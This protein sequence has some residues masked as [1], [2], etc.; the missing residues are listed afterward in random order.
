MESHKRILGIIFIVWGIL[1]IFG[2]IFLIGFFSV[3][4]PFLLQEVSPED[5]WAIEWLAPFFQT[6]GLAI[7]FV[8]A[9]PAIIAGIGLLNKKTWAPTMA[10]IFGCLGVFNF[11]VG[12]AICGYSIWVYIEDNKEKRAAA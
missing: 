7:I 2:M 8:F 11:P 10:L 1:R 5:Q 3:L 4:T 6:I 9:V 12:T